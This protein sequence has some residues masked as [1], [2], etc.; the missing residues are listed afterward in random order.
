M[1]RN[2][3]SFRHLAIAILF[4]ASAIQATTLT[5][6]R[7]SATGPGSLPVIINQAEAVKESSLQMLPRRT[8]SLHGLMDNFTGYHTPEMKVT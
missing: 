3:F 5:L 2:H 1:N 6:T 8:I 4:G 7:S